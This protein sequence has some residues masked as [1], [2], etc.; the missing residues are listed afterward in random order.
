[1]Q[2]SNVAPS[3]GRYVGGGAMYFETSGSVRVAGCV[4]SNNAAL[5]GNGGAIFCSDC[6]DV[7][8]TDSSFNNNS[9]ADLVSLLDA[10]STTS[11]TGGA[12]CVLG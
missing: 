4:F 10:C 3:G 7:L 9:A 6:G 1:M 12:K 11:G 2:K 8:V 5:Y